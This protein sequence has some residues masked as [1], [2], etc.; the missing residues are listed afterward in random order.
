MRQALWVGIPILSLHFSE[1]CQDWNPDPQPP[2]SLL[3][4]AGGVLAIVR[5][6]RRGQAAFAIAMRG[7]DEPARVVILI[8]SDVV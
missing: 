2:L 6:V 8:R 1:A 7:K 5:G 3:L 4:T